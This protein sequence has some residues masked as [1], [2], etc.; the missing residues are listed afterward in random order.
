M[1]QERLRTLAAA[2][3]AIGAVLG[4][5]GTFA[6]DASIRALL[7][8]IDGTALVMGSAL[9]A[10]H[11]LR[12]GNEQLAA[13]FLVFLAGQVLVAYGSALELQENSATLAVGAAMWAAGL[14]LVSTSTLIP[15]IVRLTGT[16]A[17]VLFAITSAQII[18]G[19]AVWA[20]TK[21]LP[22]YAFPFLAATLVGWA[23]VHRNSA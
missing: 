16:I 18:L 22:F 19:A 3:L 9:L 20:L 10:V 21:P 1:N 17:A 7:W 12:R 11:H 15:A 6:P 14:A 4:I 2:A 23:W 8:V 5:A 13:G